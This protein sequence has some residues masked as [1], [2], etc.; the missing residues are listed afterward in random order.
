MRLTVQADKG[1]TAFKLNDKNVEGDVTV[2]RSSE[3][4]ENRKLGRKILK[5]SA[6]KSREQRMHGATT[7]HHGLI[8]LP[9]LLGSERLIWSVVHVN[10][11]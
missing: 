3:H 8:L 7:V 5:M 1:Y 10:A 4:P 9:L 6:R 2:T 11:S